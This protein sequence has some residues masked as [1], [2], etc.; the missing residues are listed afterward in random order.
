M[1][2]PQ[3]NPNPEP[4]PE[5]PK[6]APTAEPKPEP[7]KVPDDV[8]KLIDA[9]AA[10]ARKEGEKAGKAAVETAA[11]EAKR[12]ADEEAQRQKDID[13]GE[14]GKVRESLERERDGFKTRAD[15]AEGVIAKYDAILAPLVKERLDAIK[16]ADADVAKG[17]P[18]DAPLLDQL[19]WLDDPRT[20]ALLAK[21]DQHREN[22][23]RFPST[24]KPNGDGKP[25]DDQARAAQARL[26]RTF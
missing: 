1:T 15:E 12:I 25:T 16:A 17:F 6:P 13:A 18:A 24:P 23:S 9:A 20:K 5:E 11:A 4:K 2:S 14:F 22:L 3:P 10:A 26:Y 7:P 19:A 8:Q 21:Q